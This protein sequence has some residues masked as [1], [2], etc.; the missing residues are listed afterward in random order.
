MIEA[1]LVVAILDDKTGRLRPS[2]QEL[3]RAVRLALR[4][5]HV[6]N[7]HREALVTGELLDPLPRIARCEENV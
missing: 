4:Q 3:D 5:V 2:V 6:A 1:D 7:G